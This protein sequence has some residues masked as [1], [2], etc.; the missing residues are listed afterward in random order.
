MHVQT[1]WKHA[2]CCSFEKKKS[3]EEYSGLHVFSLHPRPI[4]YSISSPPRGEQ[5]RHQKGAQNHLC[6][7]RE[8]VKVVQV[9]EQD[10]SCL[11]W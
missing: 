5:I 4:L 2:V 10:V 6:I 11:S 8:P 1:C 7:Y 3:D 9:S